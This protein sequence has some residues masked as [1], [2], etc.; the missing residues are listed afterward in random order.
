MLRGV[1]VVCSSSPLPHT[2]VPTKRTLLNHKVAAQRAHGGL[3]VHR[4]VAHHD[5]GGVAG[6]RGLDDPQVAGAVLGGHAVAR[7]ARAVASCKAA[8]EGLQDGGGGVGGGGGAK[9]EGG[10]DDVKH[11][12]A[13]VALLR[14]QYRVQ[15]AH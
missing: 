12:A 14:C 10:G 6:G 2:P 5:G 4:V 3:D 15:G 8:Q 1:G 13:V 7:Y 11:V 9:V